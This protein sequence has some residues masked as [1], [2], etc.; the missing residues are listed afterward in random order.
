MEEPGGLQS[1]EFSRQESCSGLP[2]PSP[3]DLPHPG[4]EPRS[5]AL[6]ADIQCGFIQ[7]NSG[8]LFILDSG[9]L[10]ILF[11]SSDG[12]DLSPLND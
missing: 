2:F 7:I 1:M 3:R 10:F 12:G 4:I 8:T 6:Q 9:V 11:K 5:P